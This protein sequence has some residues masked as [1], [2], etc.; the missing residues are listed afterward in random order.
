M[1]FILNTHNDLNGKKRML[2]M[3]DVDGVIK[4][5]TND[6]EIEAFRALETHVEIFIPL[7]EYRRIFAGKPYI[8]RG[9]RAYGSQ[10]IALNKSDE[11]F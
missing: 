4:T 5:Y 2:A 6:Q 10:S 7:S 9:L 3:R 1:T 8:A 11:D